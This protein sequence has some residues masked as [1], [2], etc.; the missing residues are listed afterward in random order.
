MARRVGCSRIGVQPALSTE[1]RVM[2]GE[3]W[4][5]S[6]Y[7]GERKG[8]KRLE[9]WAERGCS[10]GSSSSEL[11]RL[12]SEG[13]LAFERSIA[14]IGSS[15]C[16]TIREARKRSRVGGVCESG[17]REL[18]PARR[19]VVVAEEGVNKTQSSKRDSRARLTCRLE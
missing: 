9:R 5:G 15:C 3:M 8:V 11:G 12:P 10:R 18:S 14:G 19:G 4:G 7:L 13:E 16:W 1:S 2:R 17:V 6:W